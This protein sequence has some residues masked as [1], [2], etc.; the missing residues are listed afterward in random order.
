MNASQGLK[1]IGIVGTM[2]LLAVCPAFAGTTVHTL[3]A[4]DWNATATWTGS[5]VPQ[6]G[7][8]AFVDH[9][10]TLTNSTAMLAACTVSAGK[11]NKFCLD[12]RICGRV[13][14]WVTSQVY[15]KA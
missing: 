8:T 10:V 13:P 2:G 4:G 3:A 1:A 11:T 9:N 15:D 14:A 5:Y 12:A 7:D 6:D